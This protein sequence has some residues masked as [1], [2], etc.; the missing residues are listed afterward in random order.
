MFPD[1]CFNINIL[2]EAEKVLTK[3]SVNPSGRRK[4]LVFVFTNLDYF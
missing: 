2:I 3:F 1:H 4:A